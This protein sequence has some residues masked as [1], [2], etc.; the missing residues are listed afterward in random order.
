VK[1]PP[2]ARL[3]C[4]ATIEVLASQLTLAAVEAS[5]SNQ[6]TPGP[7]FAHATDQQLWPSDITRHQFQGQTVGLRT[8]VE[9]T[10]THGSG[11]WRTPLSD[12][13]RADQ[14]HPVGPARP[15]HQDGRH[16][17]S[18][19]D[20]DR[21][22]VHHPG[23]PDRGGSDPGRGAVGRGLDR[24]GCHRREPDHQLPGLACVATGSKCRRWTHTTLSLD[25]AHAGGGDRG[26][27]RS[28]RPLPRSGVARWT[29]QTVINAAA[30]LLAAAAVAS[31]RWLGIDQQAH[32][33]CPL[34]CADEDLLLPP[35]LGRSG[36]GSPPP[37][38]AWTTWSGCV[39]ERL[40]VP[41]RPRRRVA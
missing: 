26:G 4:D 28:A 17:C 22:P 33:P 40:R 12:C 36:A 7:R 20:H 8:P 23:R 16:R 15:G 38:T 34:T 31:A 13:Y 3:W 1:R 14:R 30:A 11:I 18:L 5:A 6:H 35:D 21:H 29:V 9:S 41:T 32:A 24:T 39:A 2:A 19:P 25:S 27:P 37:Q 10:F